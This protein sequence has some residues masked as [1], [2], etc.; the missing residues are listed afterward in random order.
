MKRMEKEYKAM[1]LLKHDVEH[2]KRLIV[3]DELSSVSGF[4]SQR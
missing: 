3:G 4:Q 1:N 2:A